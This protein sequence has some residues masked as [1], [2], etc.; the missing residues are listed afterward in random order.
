MKEVLI[1]VLV[2]WLLVVHVAYMGTKYELGYCNGNLAIIQSTTK[3][4]GTK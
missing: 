2:M 3:Q 4:R 1:G